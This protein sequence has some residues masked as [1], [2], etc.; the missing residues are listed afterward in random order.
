[1]TT[2]MQAAGAREALGVAHERVYRWP[3]WFRGFTGTLGLTGMDGRTAHGTLSV[4]VGSEPVVRVDG[5]DASDRDWLR[6]GVGSMVAH[7]L[8]LAFEDGDG[9]HRVRWEAVNPA[10]AD[11][12][13]AVDDGMASRYWLRDDDIWRIERLVDATLVSVVIHDRLA[14]PTGRVA[15]S[16]TVHE[17]SAPSGRIRAVEIIHDAHVVVDGVLVPSRRRSLRIEGD[18]VVAARDLHLSDHDVAPAGGRS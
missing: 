9:R 17:I 1:M 7:R 2:T 12:L 8:P 15:R 5:L 18:G 10:A 13:V 4:E 3:E 16:V 11:H 14:A 6:Q